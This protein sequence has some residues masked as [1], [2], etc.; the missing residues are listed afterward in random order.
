MGGAHGRDVLLCRAR[1]SSSLTLHT[2]FSL[3]FSPIPSP[4]PRFP[5]KRTALY[6][7]P[8]GTLIARSDANG[9]DLEEFAGE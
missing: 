6:A 4:P 3:F 1:D 2:Y 7:P 9:E 8:A 5:S